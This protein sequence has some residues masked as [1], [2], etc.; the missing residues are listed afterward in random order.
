MLV[1]LFCSAIGVSLSI[2]VCTYILQLFISVRSLP[3]VNVVWLRQPW[4]TPVVLFLYIFEIIGG[5]DMTRTIIVITSIAEISDPDNLYVDNS[6]IRVWLR[7][8]SGV[9]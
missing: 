5:G 6:P 4:A 7:I 2:I 8:T 9:H 3:A 1:S